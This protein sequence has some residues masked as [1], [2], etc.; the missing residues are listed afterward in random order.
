MSKRWVLA[1][2]LVAAAGCGGGGGTGSN[3]GYGE[4]AGV[5][6]GPDGGVV[7]GAR[8]TVS[9]VGGRTA[10]TNSAGQYVLRNVPAVDATVRADITIDGVRYVGSNLARVYDRE[11]AKSVNIT[12]VRSSQTAAIRATVRDRYGYVLQGA[13]LFAIPDNQDALSGATEVTDSNG[14]CLLRDLQS[15]IRYLV[16]ANGRGFE[17]DSVTVN[18]VAGE[19]RALN[20]V[21]NDAA[22]VALDPPTNVDAVAWTAPAAI[23]RS[24]ESGQAFRAFKDWFDAKE[25]RRP[26][27]K[28][29]STILGNPIEIDLYWDPIVDRNLFGFG[30]YRGT[31]ASGSLTSAE[32]LRDPTASF[33]A[34]NDEYLT[35]GRT[36]YYEVTC[37]NATYPDGSRSESAPS[38]RVSA[39]TLGDL[40]LD[41]LSMGPFPFRWFAAT[42]AE[43]YKVYL[44]DRFPAMAVDPVWE[45][46]FTSGTSVSYD[47]PRLASGRRYYFLVL[48]VAN[49]T[50][51]RTISDVGSFVA[52]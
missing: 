35:E 34:D 6:F 11:R 8:V 21:L 3:A 4:V 50:S 14:E 37:L 30:I 10:T 18:L 36:Y 23:S 1:G 20:F 29:R 52:N 9:G 16:V 7:R 22:D 51:S 5:V 19:T 41:P 27:A 24:R 2:L 42:G 31:N 49:G 47:G 39:R 32:L 28:T 44:Y 43:R 33:Y 17:S 26:Q 46:G 13:R 25:G 45:S 40:R 48:G 12:M 38:E 15:G